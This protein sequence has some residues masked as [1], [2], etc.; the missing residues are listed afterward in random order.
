MSYRLATSEDNELVSESE[1]QQVKQLLGRSPR[2]L[3]S[4][5]VSG[6]DGRPVVIQVASLV[7][8]KPFPT[9]FWLVDPDVNY[10][11]DRE[12]A[13]GLIADFQCQVDAS[14]VL[15]LALVKDHQAHIA[16]RWELMTPEVKERVEFLGFL[17]A[18]ENRGIGGI[19]NFQRIRCLHT[20][21]AAHL[22][23]PNTIGKLLDAHWKE[24]GVSFEHIMKA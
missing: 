22:V 9:L 24:H 14:E 5:A 13:R 7:N 18:L 2:G 4:L 3:R 16:L 17:P 1:F 8:D 6:V 23:I 19:E 20:Y 15:Q 11:I 12:E 10:A 21:Y